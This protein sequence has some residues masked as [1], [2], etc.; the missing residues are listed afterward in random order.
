MPAKITAVTTMPLVR[1]ENERL[2]SSIANTTPASG[3]L[4]AAAIAAAP[5]ARI[6]PRFMLS[7]GNDEN[8][9]SEYISAAPTCTVG[10]SRPIEAPV[11]SPV[12]VSRTLPAATRS[13]NSSRRCAGDGSLS[14][15]IV[16]GM[17]LPCA[18]P[19]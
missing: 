4:N 5:P 11:S 13:D 3:A 1:C 12:S 7:C 14:A 18:L 8:R 16:C 17:P 10:P 9:L 19:K 2:I 15:A 6:R